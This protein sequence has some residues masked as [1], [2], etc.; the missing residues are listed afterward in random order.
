MK[1]FLIGMLIMILVLTLI[2]ITLKESYL[3]GAIYFTQSDQKL[4]TVLRHSG[5]R[6]NLMRH[7][8]FNITEP[9]L[10]LMIDANRYSSGSSYKFFKDHTRKMYVSFL[11]DI[12]SRNKDKF[13]YDIN[14]STK[15][16]YIGV[17]AE[18]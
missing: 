13:E 15:V 2:S 4:K 12:L 10:D 9:A 18:K 6:E 14:E 3:P 7:Y 1:R 17:R 5:I 11:E 8:E 16:I